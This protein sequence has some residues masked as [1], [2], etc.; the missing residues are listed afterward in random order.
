MLSRRKAL[1]SLT[2]PRYWFLVSGF[3]TKASF[4][5]KLLAS[6]GSGGAGYWMFMDATSDG[7]QVI[8]HRVTIIQHRPSKGNC[9][10]HIYSGR[11]IDFMHR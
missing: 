10:K 2:D 9:Q 5:I 3:D 4:S 11:L 6:A 8:K 7:M 1:Q